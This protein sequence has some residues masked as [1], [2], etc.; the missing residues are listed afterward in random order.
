ME[1]IYFT[2]CMFLILALPVSTLVFFFV[3][4]SGLKRLVSKC[5]LWLRNSIFRLRN[6]ISCLLLIASFSISS[7]IFLL[8]L[9]SFGH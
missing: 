7:K 2:W 4:T 9:K 6:S 1:V 5:P 8:V 3:A